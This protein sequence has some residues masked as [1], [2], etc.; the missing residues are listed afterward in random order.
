LKYKDIHPTEDCHEIHRQVQV[1]DQVMLEL[2]W[3]ARR[4]LG[5][6][7]DSFNL[8]VPQ[9]V[10]LRI[11]RNAPAGC[12]MGELAAAA[13]QLS[14][15][16]TGIVDRLCEAELI[17]KGP[18]AHDRR[19]LRVHLTLAGEKVLEEIDQQRHSRITQVLTR[20]DAGERSDL[21]RLLHQYMKAALAV[22]QA[23]TQE[24]KAI[25]AG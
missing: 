11:L 9:Y 4:Q 12:T 19:A 18:D 22:N 3:D 15:T 10:A 25:G 13:Q 1:F 6:E 8:T 7:L 24:S 16:M 5:Q 23:N 14:P 17:W 21:I 20:L 2:S